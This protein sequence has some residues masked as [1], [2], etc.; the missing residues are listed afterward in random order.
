MPYSICDNFQLF[1]RLHPG[2]FCSQY[3]SLTDSQIFIGNRSPW[4]S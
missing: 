1:F 4:C 2:A 3:I